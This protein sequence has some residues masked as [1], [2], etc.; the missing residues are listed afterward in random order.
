MSDLSVRALAPS[1]FSFDQS[2]N[3]RVILIDD[4]PW[5]VAAD[6]CSA[7]NLSN[8]S[9]AVASLDDDEKSQ[10]VDPDT[11]SLTECSGIN[12]LVNVVNESGL[13]TL[14]L[15]CRNATKKGSLPHRFRKW[16]TSE[17]L[18]TIRKTGSY[19]HAAPAYQKISPEQQQQLTEAMLKAF[20]G[21]IFQSS[22][23]SIQHGYNRLRVE[24]SV[25]HIADLPAEDFAQ[26]LARVRE[27]DAMVNA[28]QH[29]VHEAKQ[30]FLTNW[31]EGGAPW[32]LWLERKWKE[33]MQAALPTRPNWIEIQRQV[34]MPVMAVE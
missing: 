5:F 27:F 2:F 21:W 1:V 16:V 18:P 9:M 23:S 25:A 32:T 19:Q 6:I 30:E 17:V 28:F 7:L 11:L 8:P 15:R 22:Q 31:I 12:N 33:K 4:E 14:V 10:V 34:Q 13:Y 29:F 26:A 24:H 20:G 3:V